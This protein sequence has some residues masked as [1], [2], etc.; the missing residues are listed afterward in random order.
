M[1][2]KLELMSMD[3]LKGAAECLKVMAHP[4]RL[5]IVDILMQGE[6]PVGEIAELC[7]LPAHQMSEHL[8]L[9]Q[10]HGLLDS[11]RRGRTVYYCVNNPRLPALLGCIKNSCEMDES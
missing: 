8:R 11:E 1:K 2:E 9:L 10:G 6:F 4:I 7:E 5:R 3:F